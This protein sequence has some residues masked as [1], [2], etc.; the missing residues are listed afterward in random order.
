MSDPRQ[1]VWIDYTNWRGERAYRKIRPVCIAFENNEWH[2]DTQWLLHAIDVATR[3]ERTFALAK[4]RFWASVADIERTRELLR[5]KH[6]PSYVQRM[7]QITYRRAE[8][9]MILVERIGL[10]DTLGN[11]QPAP[12][13]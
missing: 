13:Q 4:I 10:S 11:G 12:P 3:Y 8:E 2:P 5:E 1:E 6:S 7:M 9:M